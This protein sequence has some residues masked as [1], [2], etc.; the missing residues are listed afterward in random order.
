M[1][2]SKT[3]GKSINI[4]CLLKLIH[5]MR[6]MNRSRHQKHTSFSSNAK[7]E[8]VNKGKQSNSQ[9]TIGEPRRD[10]MIIFYLIR[11]KLF[12]S[13]D[14]LWATIIFLFSRQPIELLNNFTIFLLNFLILYASILS[15]H[16]LNLCVFC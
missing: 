6:K 7:T 13:V 10:E 16:Y 14:E 9:L 11:F 15:R 5:K 3:L 1:S 4:K 8:R 2:A 12:F